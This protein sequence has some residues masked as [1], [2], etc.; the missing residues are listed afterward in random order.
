MRIF[1]PLHLIFFL[2]LLDRMPFVHMCPHLF[3]PR[4]L[5][6]LHYLWCL[7]ILHVLTL[8]LH[9]LI[10][11]PYHLPPPPLL[12]CPRLNKPLA[13]L[14]WY[15]LP[16]HLLL[17]LLCT[18]TLW[19]LSYNTISLNQKCSMMVLLNIPFLKLLLRCV[20]ARMLNQL[21]FLKLLNMHLGVPPCS[22]T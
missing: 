19:S 2:P 9:M 22:F 5:V 10:P 15:H 8:L 6:R 14:E 16:I 11:L 20:Q 1:F 18:P 4:H 13:P 21:V 7:I 3:L 17:L 12:N